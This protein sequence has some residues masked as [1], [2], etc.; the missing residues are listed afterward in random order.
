[1]GQNRYQRSI[2]ITVGAADDQGWTDLTCHAEV[3]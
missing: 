2:Q 1:M 3:E